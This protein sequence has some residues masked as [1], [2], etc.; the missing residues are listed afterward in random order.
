MWKSAWRPRAHAAAM[1]ATFFL[2]AIPPR[3]ASG[4]GIKPSFNDLEQGEST[5]ET[6]DLNH[7]QIIQT[8]STS[9]VGFG[10]SGT[11]QGWYPAR[12]KYRVRLSHPSYFAMIGRADL[13]DRQASRDTWSDVLFWGGGVTTLGGLVLAVYG[14]ANDSTPGGVA[15]IVVASA[16]VASSTVGASL[17]TPILPTDEALRFADQYNG[18]LRGHLGLAKHSQA[19]RP[20]TPW[21]FAFAPAVQPRF[22]GVRAY[23]VF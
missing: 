8:Q 19:E 13:A 2:V 17:G 18:I 16:G 5:A 15:G 14:F 1:A 4:Q 20:A 21:R 10:F 22:L 6:Y 23:G 3:T 7:V 9:W 11:R 12:G